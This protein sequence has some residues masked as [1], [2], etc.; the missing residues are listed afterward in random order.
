VFWAD[1]LAMRIPEAWGLLQMG[2]P[3]KHGDFNTEMDYHLVI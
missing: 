2:D 1:S 3:Q